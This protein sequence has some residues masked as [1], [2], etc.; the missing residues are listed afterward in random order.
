MGFFLLLGIMN[1]TAVTFVNKFLCG[2]SLGFVPKSDFAGL[3]GNSVFN[4][5]INLGTF[6]VIISSYIL[7]ASFSRFTSRT[8][9]VLMHK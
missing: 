8:S 5:F 7:P 9:N 2:Y 6:S 4:L 1:N 3:S